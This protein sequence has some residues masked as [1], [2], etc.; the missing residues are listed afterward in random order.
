[1]EHNEAQKTNT[2]SSQENE[3]GASQLAPWKQE[4]LRLSNGGM[5]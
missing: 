5:A 3:A 4:Y 2:E 1:M